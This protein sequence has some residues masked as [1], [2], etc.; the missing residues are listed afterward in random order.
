MA[1]DPALDDNID[2]RSLDPE[3]W[4][5]I[6]HPLEYWILRESGTERAG[7]GRY[8]EDELGDGAF[9]CAG[10]SQLLY[11]AQHKFHS[12][13]GWPSFFQEVEAGALNVFRD[14][15]FGMD[16]IEMR[17]SRC[18]GHMGHIFDDAPQMPTGQRHCVNGNAILFVPAGRQ[19]HEVFA[20][21]RATV[22]RS[23][24]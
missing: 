10:C 24:L 12:G 7:T 4:R 17:C 2:P 14:T 3:E 23:R 8:T 22:Q 21:H 16:R 13:C 20:Q 5:A 1:R 15:S 11:S 9:H 18:D 6:L 19:R